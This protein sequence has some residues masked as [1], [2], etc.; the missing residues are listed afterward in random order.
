MNMAILL[1]VIILGYKWGKN[2]V[3]YVNSRNCP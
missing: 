3:V 2:M 1:L